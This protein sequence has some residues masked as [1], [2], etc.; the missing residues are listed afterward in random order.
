MNS[1]GI[2]VTLKSTVLLLYVG[3]GCP[4]LKKSPFTL[5]SVIPSTLIRF[6]KTPPPT[7]RSIN[8]T[9]ARVIAIAL[10]QPFLRLDMSACDDESME[11]VCT[12]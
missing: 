3:V 1:N 2:G 8:G 5:E 7:F 9:K 11:R 4:I 10:R 12:R 6:Y